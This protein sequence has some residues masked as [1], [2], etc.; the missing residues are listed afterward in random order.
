MTRRF[1]CALKDGFAR[2]MFIILPLVSCFLIRIFDETN[3]Q[4]GYQ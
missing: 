4:Y 1:F 2:V 3:F